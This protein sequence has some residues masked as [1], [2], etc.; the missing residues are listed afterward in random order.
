[1]K[2]KKKEKKCFIVMA[3]AG[4][5]TPAS[6]PT[7]CQQRERD[8][9][10]EVRVRMEEEEEGV[11]EERGGGPLIEWEKCDTLPANGNKASHSVCCC[12]T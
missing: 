6:E 7:L 2:R 1:M 5:L 12:R 3:A 9:N 10:T 8:R 4:S 11:R